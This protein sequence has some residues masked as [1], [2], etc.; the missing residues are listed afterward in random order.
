MF[1]YNLLY[2]RISGDIDNQHSAIIPNISICIQAFKYGIFE[3]LE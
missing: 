2:T 1:V 3:M